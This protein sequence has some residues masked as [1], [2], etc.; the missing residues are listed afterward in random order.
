MRQ[1]DAL[2]AL[3]SLELN[4]HCYNCSTLSAK[5]NNINL[6][7]KPTFA[8]QSG[9]SDSRSLCRSVPPCTG[10]RHRLRGRSKASKKGPEFAAEPSVQDV[11]LEALAV[12]SE[13]ALPMN[14]HVSREGRDRWKLWRRLCLFLFLLP[15]PSVVT[16]TRERVVGV[17]SPQHWHL[18]SASL[19]GG[20]FCESLQIHP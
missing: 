7:S 18:A 15:A 8:P 16:D 10:T 1:K 13:D 6:R 2:P 17:Q 20:L 4:R 9:T 14:R 3:R 11:C 19:L 12:S 5:R